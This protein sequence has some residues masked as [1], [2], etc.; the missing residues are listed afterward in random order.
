MPFRSVTDADELSKL[1]VAFDAAWSSIQTQH[2]L[3]DAQAQFER[4]R[5]GHIV[6]TIWQVDRDCDLIAKAVEQF[7]A[8]A[9]PSN[10]N[11]AS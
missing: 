9:V 6:F 8:T 1:R 2:L 4:D 3:P 7:L 5:L 11:P 10:S